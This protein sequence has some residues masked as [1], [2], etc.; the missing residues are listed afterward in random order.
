MYFA[1]KLSDWNVFDVRIG[2]EVLRVWHALYASNTGNTASSS[3]TSESK[4]IGS[5]SVMALQITKSYLPK[6]FNERVQVFRRVVLH[7]K[8]RLHLALLLDFIKDAKCQK[9]CDSLPVRWTLTASVRGDC[10]LRSKS[11]TS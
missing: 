1:Q 2:D 4:P 6:G 9:G 11:L 10:D 5:G 7:L 8:Q 3:L